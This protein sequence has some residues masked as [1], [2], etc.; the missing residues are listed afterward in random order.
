MTLWTYRNPVRVTFG[1]DALDGIADL[2]AGRAYALVTH[3]DAPLAPLRQRLVDRAGSPTAVIDKIQPNPSLET[4]RDACQQL[5]DAERPPEVLVALGGGSVI[6]SAKF[7]AAGRGD[8]R[9]VANHLREGVAP[10]ISALPIIAI[11]TTAGTGSDLTK[12]ATIWDPENARKLSL[13]RDDLY[14]EAVLVDPALTL[15]LPWSTTL[16]SGLDALSHALESLWN[17]NASPVSR[18]LA[19]SAAR[20]IL[21]GLA[22]LRADISDADARELMSLGALRAGLAFSNTQTA[23]AHNISYALTLEQGVAHGLACSFC[24]PDVM[25]AAL[26]ADPSCD[27]ALSDIFGDLPGAS[28]KLRDFLATLGVSTDFQDYGVAPER[29]RAIVADAFAGP[30]GRNFIGSIDRFPFPPPAGANLEVWR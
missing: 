9:S 5:L 20:D 27:A 18:G 4:L 2:L 29:W 21:A 15:G 17:V 12:W 25:A 22:G 16:A 30:R 26:G 23:L 1:W 13:A 28:A 11:P 10:T 7:L 14:P 6:D 19:V 24:L 3:P 8:W